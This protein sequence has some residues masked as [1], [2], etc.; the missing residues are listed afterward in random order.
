MMVQITN[1]NLWTNRRDVIALPTA[2]GNSRVDLGHQGA[3]LV[4]NLLDLLYYTGQAVDPMIAQC[5]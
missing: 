2:C 3:R 4:A 1:R 5:R